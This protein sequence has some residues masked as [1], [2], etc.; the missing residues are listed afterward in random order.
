MILKLFGKLHTF[1]TETW[2]SSQ[3]RDTRLWAFVVFAIVVVV[4]SWSGVRVI[5]TNYELQKKIARLQQQNEIT[6]LQNENQKLK[7][8]YLE[9]DT[10]LEL[11]AREQ[12]GKA[13]PGE[14]LI[15]VPESVALS[16]A[17]EIPMKSPAQT[18]SGIKV[19]NSP[20]YIKNLKAW[21]DFVFSH[22]L[23]DVE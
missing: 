11:A 3:W 5:E 15:L 20:S 22:K 14:K 2:E 23:Q 18:K 17:R 4:A 8:Q 1:V 19:E 21:R 9:T 6:Q 16:S 13:A 10:Y 7:N 12:F